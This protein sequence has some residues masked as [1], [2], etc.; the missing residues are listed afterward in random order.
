MGQYH[1]VVNLTK[2]EFIHPHKLGSGLKLWE[3]IASGANGGTGAALAR[4]TCSFQR[5]RRRR[6]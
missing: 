6:P 3:Q 1:V 4:A 2:R 5:T